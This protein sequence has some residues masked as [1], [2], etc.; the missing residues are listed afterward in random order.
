[1]DRHRAK[2]VFAAVGTQ[3]VEAVADPAGIDDE[4]RPE[5]RA[6]A[7]GL[8]KEIAFDVVDDDG[9]RPGQKLGGC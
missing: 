9:V 4:N 1:M 2:V 7:G 8:G 3:G 5:A 6:V